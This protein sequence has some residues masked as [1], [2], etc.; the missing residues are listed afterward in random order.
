MGNYLN[1]LWLKIREGEFD[2][3]LE[4]LFNATL[5]IAVLVFLTACLIMFRLGCF[6]CRSDVLK[7]AP[8]IEWPVFPN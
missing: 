4:G 5:N 1:Q 6:E 2:E 7:P 3:H 8:G